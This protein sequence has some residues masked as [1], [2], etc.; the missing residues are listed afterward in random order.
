MPE[1]IAGQTYLL[2]DLSINC[3]SE[4]YKVLRFVAGAVIVLFGFGF[5]A[6]FAYLLRRRK[7]RLR[8]PN[9]FAKFGFLYDGYSIERGMYWFE[10]IV[11]IR[12][13]G[14]VMIGSIISDPWYQVAGAVVLL[15]ISLMLQAQYQ[16]YKKRVFNTLEQVCLLALVVTEMI[17]LF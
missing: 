13:A 12:K 11:M 14:I 4:G 6:L 7:E 15:A 10:S 3:G 2:A 1:P 16:P 17:T 5:P 8:H 9:V